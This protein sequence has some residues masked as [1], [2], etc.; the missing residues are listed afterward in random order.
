MRLFSFWIL[1]ECLLRA[2]LFSRAVIVIEVEEDLDIVDS[3]ID[4][5]SL[6]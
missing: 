5:P 1:R 3:E 4:S 6:L 2:A